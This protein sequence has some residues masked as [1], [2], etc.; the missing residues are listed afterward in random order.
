LSSLVSYSVVLWGLSENFTLPWTDIKMPGFLLWVALIY[1]AIGTIITHLIGR[2]LAPL[3]F[4]KQRREADFRFQ[5]ARSR[6][7]TEQIALLS[8]EGAELDS[9]RDR[10]RAIIDNYLQLV[11]VRKKLTAFIAGYGQLSPI[12]PYLLTAPFYFT[13]KITLGVMTQTARAFGSVDSALNFFV[14]YYGA[15]ANFKSVLD[16][17]TSFDEAIARADAISAAPP[18][19]ALASSGA[20][21]IDDLSLGLPGGRRIVVA[22]RLEFAPGQ[23]TLLTGPSGSGKST[24]FRAIAGVWPF[25]DGR[26]TTPDGARLMLLPQRPYIPLGVLADALAYPGGRNDFSR[27][28]MIAAINDA[29]LAPFAARLDE[30]DNWV[31]RLSGGEQ[32]RVAIAR[33]LLTKPDWLFLDEATSALDEKL[34]AEIYAMLRKRLPATTIV[35]IGHRSTLHAFHERRLEMEPD[36]DGTFSPREKALA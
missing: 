8:G 7:Y 36:A 14:N 10:F 18:E 27:E 19:R 30:D 20:L 32:Q 17:L 25:F 9:L 11:D 6:E 22:P 33:A 31:Q 26:I 34:E 12:I 21:T 29:H 15:L 1:A 24:L 4:E 16:R 13:G 2:R 23:A 5:L 3:N 28:A 35:S